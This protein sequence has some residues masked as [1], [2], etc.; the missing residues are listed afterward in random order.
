MREKMKCLVPSCK[1]HADG[2]HGQ[3][4]ECIDNWTGEKTSGWI[5]QPCF[6]SMAQSGYTRSKSAVRLHI[7]Q[8]FVQ[9]IQ[10]RTI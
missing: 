7:L 4:I 8:D 2:G 6:D 9:E 5:C 3:F 1:N 10:Q